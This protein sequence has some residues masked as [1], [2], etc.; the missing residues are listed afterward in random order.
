MEVFTGRGGEWLAIRDL[1]E[2]T[3]LTRPQLTRCLTHLREQGRVEHNGGQRRAARYRLK[4]SP[5]PVA[6]RKV[7][8]HLNGA[9]EQGAPAVAA[10]SDAGPWEGQQAPPPE[11]A[12]LKDRIVRSCADDAATI[13]ELA[14][15]LDIPRRSVVTLVLELLT[16]GRLVTCGKRPPLNH[17]VYGANE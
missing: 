9:S 4:T 3:G 13:T 15:R 10:P 17:D 14:M 16:A 12:E 8:G 1:V 11:F 7:S 5:V 2:P 6:A